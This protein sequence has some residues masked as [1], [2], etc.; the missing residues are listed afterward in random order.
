MNRYA[1]TTEKRAAQRKLEADLEAY[2]G[3]V[4][5]LPYLAKTDAPAADTWRK[6]GRRQYNVPMKEQRW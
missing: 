1:V 6:T 4:E 2:E 5:R 3:Q